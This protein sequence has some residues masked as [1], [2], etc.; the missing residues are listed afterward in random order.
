MEKKELGTI[1]LD[2]IDVD[3]SIYNVGYNP[4]RKALIVTSEFNRLVKQWRLVVPV[5]SCKKNQKRNNIAPKWLT[6][7]PVFFFFNNNY[8]LASDIVF[9]FDVDIYLVCAF[10]RRVHQAPNGIS[11]YCQKGQHV[12]SRV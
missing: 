1:E 12:P 11:V 9:V 8:I 3:R 5:N 4:D 2:I 6:G 7:E 10:F